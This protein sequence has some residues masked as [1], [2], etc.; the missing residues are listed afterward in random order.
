MVNVTN[1]IFSLAN[2]KK[3]FNCAI[4]KGISPFYFVIL[5]LVVNV[6]NRVFPQVFL[7]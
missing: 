7:K 1:F 6:T 2:Q 5:I 4:S 3:I